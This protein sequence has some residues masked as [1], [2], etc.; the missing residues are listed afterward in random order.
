MASSYRGSSFQEAGQQMIMD[1]NTSSH[2]TSAFIQ[3]RA[4]PAVAV[5]SAKQLHATASAMMSTTKRDDPI[6]QMDENP[7]LTNNKYLH[8][9]G[10]S[11]DGYDSV[12]GDGANNP[13]N[14]QLTGLMPNYPKKQGK[15]FRLDLG[16]DVSFR[17]SLY[18]SFSVSVSN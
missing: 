4:K 1:H 5:F 3:A 8:G 18:S 13:L 7:A 11:F 9:T 6:L 2:N 12:A 10:A 16:Q 17:A 14:K 15:I